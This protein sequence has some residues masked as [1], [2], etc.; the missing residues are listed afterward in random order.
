MVHVIEHFS[1]GIDLYFAALKALERETNGQM[2]GKL[3]EYGL[4]GLMIRRL[5]RKLRQGLLQDVLC[6]D[7][8]L[9][10]LFLQGQGYTSSSVGA[11]GGADLPEIGEC[12]EYA[13]HFC[14]T[15][16]K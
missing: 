14:F 9:G 13:V 16:F 7:R 1:H 8:Q 12:R 6:T 10:E 3:D 5:C 2:L 15:R 4:I 11:S